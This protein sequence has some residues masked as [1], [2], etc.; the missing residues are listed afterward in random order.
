METLDIMNALQDASAIIGKAKSQLC[1]GTLPVWQKL[2]RAQTHL[3]NEM[4]ALL[5]EDSS[6]LSLP[7]TEAAPIPVA[8]SENYIPVSEFDA[9]DALIYRDGILDYDAHDA[10]LRSLGYMYLA[11]R[12]TCG[13][14]EDDGH[15]P[16]CGWGRV[17]AASVDVVPPHT[18]VALRAASA[19]Q[20][21]SNAY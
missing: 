9:H 3:D 2:K 14:S 6:P 16:C 10:Y 17:V 13:G 5:A 18:G 20:E 12:C 4:T 1:D 15:M 11:G 7:S 19:N 8:A 21:V